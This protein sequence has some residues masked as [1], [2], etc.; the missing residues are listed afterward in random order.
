[1]CIVIESCYLRKWCDDEIVCW[2]TL[3][4]GLKQCGKLRIGD[5]F[6]IL[7]VFHPFFYALHI[8]VM[9]LAYLYEVAKIA[10]IL[11]QHK[12]YR[13]AVVETTF[14]SRPMFVDLYLIIEVFQ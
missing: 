4:V 13:V 1:M 7:S 6:V 12:T 14:R 3:Y 10:K 11:K 9:V 8:H 5:K 2:Q